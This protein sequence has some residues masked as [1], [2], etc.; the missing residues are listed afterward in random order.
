MLQILFRNFLLSIILS[1]INYPKSK[2]LSNPITLVQLISMAPYQITKKA[3][4]RIRLISYKNILSPT[5]QGA[6][7][8]S[9]RVKSALE[10]MGNFI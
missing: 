4:K 8:S 10:E 1:P 5:P 9:F 3:S 6:I 7:E 2:N